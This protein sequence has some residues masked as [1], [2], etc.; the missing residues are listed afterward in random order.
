MES[1]WT[2]R[3]ERTH[4]YSSSA[5]ISASNQRRPTALRHCIEQ[6]RAHLPTKWINENYLA[7]RKKEGRN[8]THKCAN[9]KEISSDI[10]SAWCLFLIFDNFTHIYECSGSLIC[11]RLLCETERRKGGFGSTNSHTH[12]LKR[13]KTSEK[14]VNLLKTASWNVSNRLVPIRSDPIQPN[15]IRDQFKW[16]TINL[17]K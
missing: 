7:K 11:I 8:H 9:K 14:C 13:E 10:L 5:C 6:Q 15:P 12:K 17:C 1:Q 4:H 3:G 2:K 16:Q